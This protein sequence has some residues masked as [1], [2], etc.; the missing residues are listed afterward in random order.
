MQIQK[1]IDD[2]GDDS[3][4]VR[5]RVRGVFPATSANALIGPEDVEEAMKR[6]YSED[7]FNFASVILGVDVARQGDDASVIQKRQGI[8]AF[9]SES[10]NIPDTMLVANKVANAINEFN[11][12]ATFIDATGG[13]GVG[14]IDALRHTRYTPVEVYFSGK[15]TDP[16]YFNKRS[17]MWF[18]MAAWIK[19]GGALPNDPE[20]AEELCAASYTFQGDKFRLCDKD[21]IKAVIGRS[22]DKADALALTFAYPVAPRPHYLY[23][24]LSASDKLTKERREYNPYDRMKA[25]AR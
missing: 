6:H 20:L 23:G 8:V 13:Y 11:A 18:E 17:E 12:D 9:P 14:V 7:K 15:A 4:F 25:L 3:D 21:E 16:R 22:P 5:V 2:Y 1:W 24:T 10:M 19:S